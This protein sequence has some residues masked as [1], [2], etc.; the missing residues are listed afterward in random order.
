MNA[1]TKAVH[2][3]T[4]TATVT[5][6]HPV[7]VDTPGSWD[8]V[9]S[10]G[11]EG[12]Q[13]R[14]GIRL[15]VPPGW[16]VPKLDDPGAVG[17]TSVS[18]DSQNAVSYRVYLYSGRWIAVELEVGSLAEGDRIIVHYG[19][20]LKGSSGALSPRV[21][22]DAS[23][24]TLLVDTTGYFNYTKLPESPTI[25]VRPGPPYRFHVY[26]PSLYTPGQKTAVFVQAVD[27]RSNPVAY[28]GTIEVD[29]GDSAGA[30]KTA[31]ETTELR[32]TM[33]D[34]E[35]AGECPSPVSIRVS[36]KE[37]YIEGLSN[38]SIPAERTGSHLYWGEIHGHS[39]ESD[40]CKSPEFYYQ[41]A[42]DVSH[43]DFCAL[44]DHDSVGSNSNVEEHSKMMTDETWE[45]IKRITNEFNSPGQFAT[46]LAFEYTQTEVEVVGH[47][48]V[49]FRGSDAPLLRCWDSRYNTPTKL[50]CALEDYGQPAI[51]IPHHSLNFMSPEHHPHFQRLFEIY[52]V[53]GT[54]E[55][56]GDDCAFSHPTKYHRGGVSFREML[57]RG[58]RVGVVA[59]GDNHDSVPGIRQATDLWRKGR[60]AQHPGLVALYAP[61][62]T[63]ES[64]FDALWNRRCYGTTG[65]RIIL[66]F[67]IDAQPM[68]S[69]ITVTGAREARTIEIT[70]VGTTEILAV[71]VFR[72]GEH[73]RSFKPAG[74]SFAETI[75]D[76]DPILG[77]CSYYVRLVQEDG[78]RAWSSP[79]WVDINDNSHNE[80]GT[81]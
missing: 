11:V 25:D 52:S 12:V 40:G 7:D 17:Y 77:D 39:S 34:V 6:S 56:R 63:R 32:S 70:C 55:T 60:M 3:S 64:I 46:L 69:E 45:R 22:T 8:F 74:S 57:A 75:T 43:L 13:A 2:L 1:N 19:D 36:D 72:N 33:V 21:P 29:G 35:L 37:R 49:Y 14:G 30:I 59:G 79:I 62:L 20:P 65:E 48:N 26:V 5:P 9:Y 41:Y 47:R 80:R 18:V 51:V 76:E 50:F 10:A 68:G 67:R 24:F 78:H 71:D 66:D 54:S 73:Y 28:Q 53:W 27:R 4:G 31:C 81:R 16:S 44:T 42:R 38:P 15:Y 61:D 58:Y 23:E